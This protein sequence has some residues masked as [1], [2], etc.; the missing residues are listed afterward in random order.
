MS[1]ALTILF[2]KFPRPIQVSKIHPV[3]PFRKFISILM[4]SRQ[5]DGC[6]TETGPPGHLPSPSRA[7]SD[8]CPRDP[9]KNS[10]SEPISG[11]L[12]S[13]AKPSIDMFSSE[14]CRGNIPADAQEAGGRGETAAA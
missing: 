11:C 6:P 8:H 12:R 2:N 10:S 1:A 3:V 7:R 5:V 9:G 13:P 14:E 4:V